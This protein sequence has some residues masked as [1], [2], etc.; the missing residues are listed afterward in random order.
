MVT[1]RR[2]ADRLMAG[3]VLE[4]GNLLPGL[5]LVPVITEQEER[6]YKK[7]S[8][9]RS[10]RE[11]KRRARRRRRL[12]GGSRHTLFEQV[13]RLSSAV[14]RALRPDRLLDVPGSAI[15]SGRL[16]TE[17]PHEKGRQPLV[18]YIMEGFSVSTPVSME[19]M[20]DLHQSI[21]YIRRNGF[22]VMTDQTPAGV[23]R[24]VA[25]KCRPAG[26]FHGVRS[27]GGTCRPVRP[28]GYGQSALPALQGLHGGLYRLPPSADRAGKCGLRRDKQPLPAI[29][30]AAETV[31]GMPPQGDR[32]RTL[33]PARLRQLRQNIQTVRMDGSSGEAGNAALRFGAGK[34]TFSGWKRR[35][36]TVGSGSK[37]C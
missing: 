25:R 5:R 8:P 15:H 10:A 27:A 2:E 17:S 31:G 35:V 36:T 4:I 22:R 11:R 37:R 18:R 1:L 34:Y 28:T 19:P 29:S 30:A 32:H 21:E 16:R 33:R 23:A 9:S 6:I 7:N 3:R 13:T 24:Q 14:H 26:Q 20:L 12:R